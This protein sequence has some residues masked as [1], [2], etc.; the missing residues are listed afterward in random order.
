MLL[1]IRIPEELKARVE[2]VVARGH[3]SDFNSF[4][5]TAMENLLVAE[6]DQAGQTDSAPAFKSTVPSKKLATTVAAESPAK[7]P[8]P[9]EASS[10]PVFNWTVPRISERSIVPIP[11]DLFTPGQRVPVERWIFGQQNR[12]LPLKVNARLFLTLISQ[13]TSD[14]QLGGAAEA[15]SELAFAVSAF[16]AG[17]D[18]RFDHGKDD[19]LSTGFPEPDSD[20]A[21]SRYANHFV[22]YETSQGALTGMLIQ[23]KLAGVK[24]AKNKTYLLPTSPCF[25][26]AS[27]KNPLLDFP[28]TERPVEKFTDQEISWALAHIQKNVPVEGFAFMT[29]LTGIREGSVTPDALDNFIRQAACEKS[30][31]SPAFVSTQRSGA[32]SRMA[33]LN[34]V[35]RIREGTK[36]S[37]EITERGLQWL[38]GQPQPKE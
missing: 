35:R 2:A 6:E 26:F 11:N 5:V 17:L 22:A 10:S 1:Y 29:V 25:E 19:L 12:L 32:V 4:A 21:A 14:V 13:A 23:W 34:L 15:V 16:L 33:D 8:V 20:K 9:T 37:Y 3:Y 36:F 30:E 38:D 24:R 27:L 31:T 7:M 28:I 18:R